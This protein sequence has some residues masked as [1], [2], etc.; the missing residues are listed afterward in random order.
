MHEVAAIRGHC[1]TAVTLSIYAHASVSGQADA[2]RRL[3]AVLAA[4]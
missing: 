2:M 4:V 3:D 1:N